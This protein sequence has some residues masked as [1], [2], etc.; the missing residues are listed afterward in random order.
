MK[1]Q[2]FIDDVRQ[3]QKEIQ[4][5]NVLIARSS[6]E[7]IDIVK[8]KKYLP[9]LISFD[10]D[11]GRTDTSMKFIHWLINEVLDNRI[12]WNKNIKILIHSQNPV[13]RENIKS[14]W[15]SFELYCNQHLVIE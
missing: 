14:L 8:E 4:W 3:P 9:T 13:G 6:N 7:A 5:D 15:S 11:L 1:Y 2:L 12:Q 10:H